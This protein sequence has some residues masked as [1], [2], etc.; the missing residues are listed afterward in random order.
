[1]VIPVQLCSLRL[2]VS[3][4]TVRNKV[5]PYNL[6]CGHFRYRRLIFIRQVAP[7]TGRLRVSGIFPPPARKVAACARSKARAS[8]LSLLSSSTAEIRQE[9][10]E[11]RAMIRPDITDMQGAGLSPPGRPSPPDPKARLRLCRNKNCIKEFKYGTGKSARKPR[12]KKRH[13]RKFGV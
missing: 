8:L 7:V 3:G 9:C 10:W 13:R 4:R 1:M 11:R 2:P 12:G 6:G 5:T